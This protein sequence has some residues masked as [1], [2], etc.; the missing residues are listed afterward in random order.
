MDER[1]RS[2]SA[3]RR[4]VNRSPRGR[5][6]SPGGAVARALREWR[7]APPAEFDGG[8]AAQPLSGSVAKVL[9][10]LGLEGRMRESELLARWS[11]VVGAEIAAHARPVQ[12]RQGTLVVH[13]D[14]PTWM[15]ELRTM[16]PLMVRRINA[17][18]GRGFV[19]EIQF[20][21]DG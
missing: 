21:A 16:K 5:T 8:S 9:R 11:E 14:H 19:R 3:S 13:V 18:L 17:E 4:A 6:G 7:V 12:Y 1:K 10:S 2:A 15:W 20:R